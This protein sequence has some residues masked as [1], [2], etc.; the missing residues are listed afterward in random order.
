MFRPV[1]HPLQS[2]P[3]FQSGWAQSKSLLGSPNTPG[4]GKAPSCSSE[5]LAAGS[6]QFRGCWPTRSHPKSRCFI[7]FRRCFKLSMRVVMIKRCSAVHWIWLLQLAELFCNEWE[8]KWEFWG[9]V[10]LAFVS[11][12]DVCAESTRCWL[13]GVCE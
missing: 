7:I 9:G 13:G 4:K 12:G 10:G 2:T 5:P 6:D 1:S 3:P 8:L 11:T